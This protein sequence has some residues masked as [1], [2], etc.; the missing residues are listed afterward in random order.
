MPVPLPPQMGGIA[1]RP[2]AVDNVAAGVAAPQARK[3]LFYF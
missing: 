3:F 2:I 1:L